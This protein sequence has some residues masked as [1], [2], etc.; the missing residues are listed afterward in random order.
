MLLIVTNTTKLLK[1]S[2]LGLMLFSLMSGSSLLTLKVSQG[3]GR[4][5][6]EER[7]EIVW[8]SNTPC[9]AV[10]L[11]FDDGPS[12]FFTVKILD[13]L[14]EYNIQATFF[15]SGKQVERFPHVLIRAFE[16]KHEI[17]NHLYSH[18][19]LS[20]LNEYQLKQELIQTHNLVKA[21]TGY[22]MNLFRPTNGYYDEKVVRAAHSLNYN[23]IMWSQDSRDWSLKSGV[24]IANSILKSVN[25]GQIFLF[26][27]QGGDRSNTI[28][29]LQIIVPKL[30]ASGYRFL[31]VSELLRLDVKSK[32]PTDTKVN[33]EPHS[34]L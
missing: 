18:R 2:L 14:K 26:H 9:K 17:A 3:K 34:S 1:L 24:E 21:I 33:S 7:G 23:V 6:F 32:R 5:Y 22:S 27:D 30:R 13:L 16:E 10:A 31:T 25:S 19:P 12:P 8:E 28:E 20:S 4:A 11:T 29:T 15:V